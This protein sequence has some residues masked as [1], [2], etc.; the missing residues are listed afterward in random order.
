MMQ[1]R[2][3]NCSVGFP[4]SRVHKLIILVVDVRFQMIIVCGRYGVEI[5]LFWAKQYLRAWDQ[6]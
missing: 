3:Y 5:L 4:L 6:L 1:H 2:F